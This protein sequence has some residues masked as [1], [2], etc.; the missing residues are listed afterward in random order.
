[1][2]EHYYRHL[3]IT[4]RITQERKLKFS[5]IMVISVWFSW[6]VDLYMFN[7]RFCSDEQREK[8]IWWCWLCCNI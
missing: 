7:F 6:A 8:V 4:S 1:M 3:M 5:R 2:I